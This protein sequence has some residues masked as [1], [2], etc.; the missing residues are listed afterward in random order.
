MFFFF[1]LE[2]RWDESEP[3]CQMPWV[4]SECLIL[5][6]SQVTLCFPTSSFIKQNE[7]GLNCCVRVFPT[8][9]IRDN[10]IVVGRGVQFFYNFRGPS[11]IEF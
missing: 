4:F 8:F 11:K 2:L 3:I 1:Y 9:W 6:F 7:K 10:L 5:C